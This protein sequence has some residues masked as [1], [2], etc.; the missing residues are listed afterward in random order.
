MRPYKTPLGEDPYKH[1]FTRFFKLEITNVEF[2]SAETNQPILMDSGDFQQG[3]VRMK[4]SGGSLHTKEDVMHGTKHSLNEDT[5]NLV[6]LMPNLIQIYREGLTLALTPVSEYISSLD[7]LSYI[8]N[9]VWGEPL[10]YEGVF[11]GTLIEPAPN[12]NQIEAKCFLD[13]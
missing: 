11:S 4:V 5:N 2:R 7:G 13:Y 9:W 12:F 8:M 3:L 6:I 1:A 10:S